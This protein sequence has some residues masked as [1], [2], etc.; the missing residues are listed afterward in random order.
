[1]NLAHYIMLSPFNFSL[2]LKSLTRNV[3]LSCVFQVAC[4]SLARRTYIRASELAAGPQ[5]WPAAVRGGFASLAVRAKESDKSKEDSGDLSGDCGTVSIELTCWP[6]PAPAVA[7][8]G[9]WTQDAVTLLQRSSQ[10]LQTQYHLAH[11]VPTQ[12]HDPCISRHLKTAC[13]PYVALEMLG[14]WRAPDRRS[15]RRSVPQTGH[16]SLR[17][18]AFE[19]AQRCAAG[20][21][22]LRCATHFEACTWSSATT[23]RLRN[24]PRSELPAT[25]LQDRQ[26]QSFAVEG[27]Q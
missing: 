17:T 2:Q 25:F 27:L 8:T 18:G 16:H 9:P 26:L 10:I 11:E 15:L 13:L 12:P 23:S 5:P 4:K 1:M 19:F 20:S 3:R 22:V 7:P 6:L 21:V 24:S 14:T